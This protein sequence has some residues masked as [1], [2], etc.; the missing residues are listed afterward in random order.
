MAKSKRLKKPTSTRRR[1]VRVGRNSSSVERIQIGVKRRVLT[2]AFMI[3]FGAL[4]AAIIII[5]LVVLWF[6]KIY[7]DPEHVFWTTINAGLATQ[8][9]TKN[10]VRSSGNSSNLEITAISFAPKLRLHDVK[11]IIDSSTRP[12]SKLTLET[13]ASASTDYQRYSHIERPNLKK[14]QKDYQKVYDAWLKNGGQEGAAGQL[15]GN[16]VFGGVLFGDFNSADRGQI[17]N[18][19]RKA[20]LVDF[21]S[22]NKKGGIHRRVYIYHAVVPL[23]KYAVAARDYAKALDLPLARQIDP[24][25]YQPADQLNLNITVDV[26]SREVKKIEYVSQGFSESFS[27]QGNNLN[28]E[29]PQKTVSAASF[30]EIIKQL[31]Q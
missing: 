2:P 5:F 30:A 19:L 31:N 24:S 9:V 20:Y 7:A 4:A 16:A 14:T 22:V 8:S 28:I 12:S 1:P 27:G 18:D 26:L 29:L 10:S 17:F 11:Q 23:S 6:N 21:A 3:I 13:V 15:A 25:H